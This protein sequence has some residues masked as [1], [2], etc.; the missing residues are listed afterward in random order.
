MNGGNGNGT[1]DL[2]GVS[3]IFSQNRP[4]F[5]S[6]ITCT[7]LWFSYQDMATSQSALPW[8]L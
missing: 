4:R 1:W 8:E 6:M 2:P 5:S 7:I 3:G